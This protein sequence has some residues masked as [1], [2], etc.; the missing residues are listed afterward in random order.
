MKWCW[1]FAE[2]NPRERSLLES[3]MAAITQGSDVAKDCLRVCLEKHARKA[4]ELVAD[5]HVR[6]S[7]A[8]GR[9]RPC[10][11]WSTPR[12]RG[13]YAIDVRFVEEILTAGTGK[14]RRSRP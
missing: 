4:K 7:W 11:P 13:A 2:A 8:S 1:V 9:C 10:G 5:T 3:L 6:E 12:R 14:P